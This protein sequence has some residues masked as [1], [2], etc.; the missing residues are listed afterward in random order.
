MLVGAITLRTVMTALLG[1]FVGPLIDKKNGARVL[2]PLGAFLGGLGLILM[3]RV[4][5]L[6]HFYMP[7]GVFG[8]L[9]MM[10]SGGFVLTSLVSKWFVRKRGRA[11]ATIVMGTSMGGFALAPLANWLIDT[12][13]WRTAWVVLGLFSWI[14]IIPAS[15]LLVRRR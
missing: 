3:A 9:S 8:A 5:T 6:W 10:A 14:L 15:I 13:E 12:Q 11:I 1:P 4:E 2:V 7:F